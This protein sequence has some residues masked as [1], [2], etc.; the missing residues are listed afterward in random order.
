MEVAAGIDLPGLRRKHGRSMAYRGGFDKRCIAAGPQ[1]IDREMQ[2]LM[3][4]VE[5]GGYIPGCDHGV[6]ADV[7]W[8]NFVYY[9]GVLARA[10]GW[11]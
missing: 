9:V 3:P 1:A 6:P 11:L 10:T 8:D 4:V 2:R 7:S 5:S